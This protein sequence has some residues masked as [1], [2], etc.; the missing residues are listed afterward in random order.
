MFLFYHPVSIQDRFSRQQTRPREFHLVTDFLKKE[1]EKSRNFLVIADR[2]GQYTALD[3]G[4]VKFEYANAES[5]IADKFKN[6][7]IDNIFVIQRI[8]YKTS[9]PIQTCWLNS[10]YILKK[11]MESQNDENQFIRI[12]KVVSITPKIGS[13]KPSTNKIREKEDE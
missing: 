4:A 3:Y 10:N 8:E 13:A 2:P 6:H 5:S 12:S 7:L 9:K 1:R 11:V